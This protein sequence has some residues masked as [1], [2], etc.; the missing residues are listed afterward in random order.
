MRSH[1]AILGMLLTAALPT[2]STGHATAKTV[3]L[4]ALD[5]GWYEADGS[6]FVAVENYFTGFSTSQ[7]QEVRSFIMFDLS[8]VSETVLGA[9]LLLEN[10]NPAGYLSP[11]PSEM[12]T[13]FDVTSSLVALRQGTG[14]TAAFDDLGSG[15]VFGTRGVSSADNGGTVDIDLGPPAVAALDGAG[16]LFAFGGTLTTLSGQTAVDEVVFRFSSAGF[17]RQ[18]ELTLTPVPLA[19]PLLGMALGGLWLARRRV[20]LSARQPA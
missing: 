11:D 8:G 18:L 12:L 17:A 13:I 15:T 14:G 9:R 19:L 6:H 20:G 2:L 3:V 1:R 4:D 16:G 7:G 5:S 10:S